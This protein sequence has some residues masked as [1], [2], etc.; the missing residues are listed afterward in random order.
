MW[1]SPAF[2]MTIS[3]NQ[4][5]IMKILGESPLDKDAVFEIERF[6]KKQTINVTPKCP[7]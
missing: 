3:E 1:P 7:V 2:P 4:P 6:G 5:D